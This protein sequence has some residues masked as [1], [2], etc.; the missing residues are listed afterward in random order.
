M[1]EAPIE[2]VNNSTD[3]LIELI[4]IVHLFIYNGVRRDD[5]LI[6]SDNFETIGFKRFSDGGHSHSE[7]FAY[8]RVLSLDKL[9]YYASHGVYMA[10]LGACKTHPAHFLCTSTGSFGRSVRHE[11]DVL[12]V[13]FKP[14][15]GAERMTDL[16]FG[17]PNDSI[18]VKEESVVSLSQPLDRCEIPRVFLIFNH[19]IMINL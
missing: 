10:L 19:F 1:C 15:D 18:T 17:L 8:I 5:F 3:I 9:G 13:R 16:L 4:G 7:N 2:A 14:L 6:S 12:A 11:E